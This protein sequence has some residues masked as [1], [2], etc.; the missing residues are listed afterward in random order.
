[1][2]KEGYDPT[3]IDSATSGNIKNINPDRATVS[4]ETKEMEEIISP[5]R[6]I[7]REIM[8]KYN[9]PGLPQFY[10]DWSAGV[11]RFSKN[12]A[13]A[14][15]LLATVGANIGEEKK[16]G[17]DNE[18]LTDNKN[19]SDALKTTDVETIAHQAQDVV[20]KI[21]DVDFMQ[22]FTVK[23]KDGKESLNPGAF[24]IPFSVAISRDC[25]AKTDI[26]IRIPYDFAR[27][28]REISEKNPEAREELVEKLVKFINSEIQNQTVIRGIAGLTDTALIYDNKKNEAYAGKP[29]VDFG[30]MDISNIAITGKASA[31]VD[32]KTK[33]GINQ[34]EGSL[35]GENPENV[36]LARKRLKNLRPIIIEALERTGVDKS[37]L[38]NIKTSSIE[39]NLLDS[40]IAN[41]AKMS[42]DILGDSVADDEKAAYDLVQEINKSNPVVMKAINNNPKYV[43][44]IKDYI[45]DQ[46]SVNI[47]FTADV[48]FGKTDVF[49][50]A[51]P[52]PLLLLLIPGI[53]VQ[54]T[55]G[56]TIIV[57][58]YV[59]EEVPEVKTIKSIETVA[60]A[61]RRL[62]SE[63][64]PTEL[65]KE[66]SFHD[67]YESVDLSERAQDTHALLQHMLLEEVGPSLN[68]S[69]REPMID[70]EKITRTCMES[71]Y[72]DTGD[73]VKK[74]SYPT[75]ED[76]QRK[77]TEALLDMWEKHDMET[78]KM[79]GIDIK[80]VLNY[81]HSDKVIF[82]A[83]TLAYD[84]VSIALEA[85]SKSEDVTEL[86]KRIDFVE[87]L[88]R[89]IQQAFETREQ[90]GGENRNIFV[91]S[92]GD[93]KERA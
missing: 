11:K 57:K 6:I 17:G 27:T 13:L 67:I 84:F 5:K 33:S 66:R 45:T 53:R 32:K 82:W 89:H 55:Q 64:T 14:V 18:N 63:K 30:H 61:K 86:T 51:L 52:L 91:V 9:I 77:T 58:D 34:G 40:Q 46:R 22:R 85:A 25:T 60:T 59:E 69:T 73:G 38:E 29:A 16:N 92:N 20:S 12:T 15:A 21:V 90:Q 80:T 35:K 10:F 79:K 72:S 7:D 75:I 93:E 78:Y 43:E 26:E 48:E 50:V 3:K 36:E 70:Y 42:H 44:M 31:E 1:M 8:R 56:R 4:L 2:F 83:K 74:G 47:G 68:D 39:S 54:K 41:L 76:S 88:E 49:N 87:I 65:D 71:L 24:V 28:F 37:A 81:R 62:F 23:D 19:I